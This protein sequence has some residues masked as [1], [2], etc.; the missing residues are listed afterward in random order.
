MKGKKPAGKGKGKPAKEPKE[1][2]ALLTLSGHQ[3]P[4]FAVAYKP[5]G[6]AIATGGFDGTVRLYDPKTGDLVKQFV[7]VPIAGAKSPET[8]P[9]TLPAAASAD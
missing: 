2:K 6:S 8:R 7:P 5:D 9:T 3:G 4:V 1:T